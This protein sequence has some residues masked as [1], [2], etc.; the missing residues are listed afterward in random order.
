MGPIHCEGVTATLA[1]GFR[2]GSG[3]A[4]VAGTTV[5]GTIAAGSTGGGGAVSTGREA[6]GVMGGCSGSVGASDLVSF[7]E[8]SSL[9]GVSGVDPPCKH[10]IGILWSAVIPLVRMLAVDEHGVK[11]EDAQASV[12]RSKMAN[13]MDHFIFFEA[14]CYSDIYDFQS[15]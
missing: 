14:V 12:E 1:T 15:R 7:C 3:G 4:T 2:G 8:K 11:D 6:G 9:D 5:A 13:P 10:K